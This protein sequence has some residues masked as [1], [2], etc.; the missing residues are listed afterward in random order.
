MNKKSLDASGYGAEF[1]V[2]FMGG[3]FDGLKDIVINLNTM[4]P[5]KYTYR[6]MNKEKESDNQPKL[7]I[8]LIEHWKEKHLPGDTRVAIYRL[9]GDS[10]DYD[11]EDYDEEVC[12]YDFLEVSNFDKYRK[13]VSV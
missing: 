9:R 3:P 1:D 10:E 7:G 2:E 11:S 5:P 13:L 6:K 12:L 4:Y 8:K